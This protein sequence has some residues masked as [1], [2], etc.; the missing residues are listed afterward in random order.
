M[1]KKSGI[2]AI[3]ILIVSISIISLIVLK[4]EGMFVVGSVLTTAL[5]TVFGLICFV[6]MMLSKA[7]DYDERQLK[8]RGDAAVFSLL[9]SLLL[10]MGCGFLSYVNDGRFP[11]SLF[12]TSMMCSG[13][14]MAAF[15]IIADLN[16][17]YLGFKQK[18]STFVISLFSLGVIQFTSSGIFSGHMINDPDRLAVLL[19]MG[20]CW[21]AVGFEMLFKMISEKRSLELERDDEES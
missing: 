13:I 4:S 14:G 7:K 12:A 15:I 21:F 3:I 8:A 1:N 5:I 20:S 6:A 2:A 18:R 17:A 11:F 10:I 9:L 19:T 16:D